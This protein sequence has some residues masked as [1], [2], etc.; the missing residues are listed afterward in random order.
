MQKQFSGIGLPWS[1]N[2]YQG[3]EA[4]HI[5]FYTGGTQCLHHA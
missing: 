4:A 2:M 5:T 1:S 3:D